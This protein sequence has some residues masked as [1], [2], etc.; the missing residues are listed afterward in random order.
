MVE[1]SLKPEGKRNALHRKLYNYLKSMPLSLSHAFH[2]VGHSARIAQQSSLFEYLMMGLHW[3]CGGSPMSIIMP[4]A[5][6]ANTVHL[7]I[8]L[9]ISVVFYVK[10]EA[11]CMFTPFAIIM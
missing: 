8:M 9:I 2:A 6:Y 10:S 3:W 4:L 1:R 7:I 11:S 5:G